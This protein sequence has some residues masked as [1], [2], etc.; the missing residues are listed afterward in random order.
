[1]VMA[2]CAKFSTQ[3][4]LARINIY[5]VTDRLKINEIGLSMPPPMA[6]ASHEDDS[7]HR[8]V[9]LDCLSCGSLGLRSATHC[10]AGAVA[11]IRIKH[12]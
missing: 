5:A 9:R 8:Q 12:A 3:D 7:L 2:R 4:S 10:T 1:M 11:C 6:Y